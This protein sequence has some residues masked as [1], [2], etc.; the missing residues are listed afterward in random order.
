VEQVVKHFKSNEK[1][2]MFGGYIPTNVIGYADKINYNLVLWRTEAQKVRMLFDSKLKI[3]DGKYHVPGL[4]WV[5]GKELKLYA[6]KEWN[7]EK[8][9]LFFA[10]FHNISEGSV[11]L[12]TAMDYL[13]TDVMEYTFRDVTQKVEAAF[14]QSKFTHSSNDGQIN[15]TFVGLYSK[16]KFEFPYDV[17]ISAD[18]TIKELSHEVFGS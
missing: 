1:R 13:D 11:C 9:Q 3:E 7:G 12:G 14:W 15:G 4:V 17:L 18:K 5:F 6:Y 10:P 2:V 16:S 8:T